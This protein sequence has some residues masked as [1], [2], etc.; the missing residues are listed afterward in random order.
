[1]TRG[2]LRRFAVRL[3]GL[4][5]R[6]QLL[7]AVGVVVVLGASI[8]LAGYMSLRNLQ[9]GMETMLVR[10]SQLREAGLQVQK[11]FLL[12][13]VSEQA[14]LQEWH[15]AGLQPAVEEHVTALRLR[16]KEARAQLASIRAHATGV[17]ERREFEAV[18]DQLA[19]LFDGYETGFNE[20]LQK[21]AMRAAGDGLE[22]DLRT[23]VGAIAAMAERTG[24]RR[25]QELAH[26]LESALQ[27]YLAFGRA[28]YF[29]RARITVSSIVA[30]PAATKAMRRL[31]SAYLARHVDLTELQTAVEVKTAAFLDTTREILR[32]TEE[33]GRKAELASLS[34]ERELAAIGRRGVGILL[35]A[36]LASAVASLLVTAWLSR[37]IAQPLE[38]LSE[39]SLALAGGHVP[40]P[41]AV[42]GSGEIAQLGQ[43][44]NAMVRDVTARAEQLS[45][46]NRELG[47]AIEEAREAREA[48]ETASR[49]KSDFLAVMSH[50]IR[51][52]M[53]GVLGAAELLLDTELRSEQHTLVDTIARSGRSLLSVINDILDF[54]KIEAG[55]M[56]LESVAFD[57]R[58]VI[59]D[60]VELLAERADAKGLELVSRLPAYSQHL[61]L[62]DPGR[63]RQ[64]LS[65]LVGN[66]IKFTAA[67]SVTIRME[68]GTSANPELV[69]FEV[70]DTGIGIPAAKLGTVFEAFSQADVSTTRQYGGTGLGLAI[71]KRLSALMG[72]QCGVDSTEGAGSTFWFTARLPSL[73]VD[74][75]VEMPGAAEMQG[76][77][78]L[79]VE[80]RIATRESLASSLESFAAIT[81][82]ASDTVEAARLA[83]EA[84][85]NDS[86]FDAVLVSFPDTAD[87]AARFVDAM[88]ALPY[89]R[90]PRIVWLM[91]VSQAA[92]EA[93]RLKAVDGYVIKP[94]RLQPLLQSLQIALAARDEPAPETVV[95]AT[96]TPALPG[97]G[98]HVLVVEDNPVNQKIACAMLHKMGCTFDL[99]QDGSEAI[100]MV[101]GLA[102]D[103][104][105]MDCQMPVMDGF[106]ATRE[107][108]VRELEGQG[109]WGR[110]RTFIVALTAN[111][112]KGDRELCLAA[113]MDDYLSKPVTR[114]TLGETVRKAAEKKASLMAGGVHLADEDFLDDLLPAQARSA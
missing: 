49:A 46:I 86:P 38:R 92:L 4:S 28:E 70:V 19:G 7:A 16:L 74:V 47:L 9:A 20:A 35:L 108:R 59:E 15:T 2:A 109:A 63:L 45:S 52:P 31:A 11:A 88:H 105:L 107:I 50:E 85:D 106:E 22:T 102:Y 25:L 12:V 57:P 113:G 60:V 5:L 36:T 37:R 78:L 30:H 54:S 99:A 67:G 44:F 66:A 84:C 48:A 18:S 51:T 114:D 42:E 71:V 62:G 112:M 82:C 32:T 56:E 89:A 1:M 72:G 68:F 91:S 14:F 43:V 13:R 80:S 83:Q 10:T 27:N 61:V 58:M 77:R 3:Q 65:N 90:Q 95:V 96:D 26:D 24:D 94:V 41:L 110:P 34:A 29:D 73:T 103:L 97:S 55:R 75:P 21:I 111:A 81:T 104:V 76:K 98:L 40:S 69:R 23:R 64:V 8:A 33:I 39:A 93:P 6:T 101:E 79:I 17:D 53:N 87:D 100:A